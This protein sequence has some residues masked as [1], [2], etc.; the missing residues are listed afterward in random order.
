ML[1]SFIAIFLSIAFALFN[2]IRTAHKIK[3]TRRP[4]NRSK[5]AEHSAPEH[6]TSTAVAWVYIGSALDSRPPT[7]IKHLDCAPSYPLPAAPDLKPSRPEATQSCRGAKLCFSCLFRVP[8]FLFSSKSG[9][10]IRQR[11]STLVSA[12]TRLEYQPGPMGASQELW[13]SCASRRKTP[14]RF[15]RATPYEKPADPLQMRPLDW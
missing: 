9:S 5:G 4:I 12:A 1:S 10:H 15:P 11:P 8:Y 13:V 14:S 2:R 7:A 3:I 6:L